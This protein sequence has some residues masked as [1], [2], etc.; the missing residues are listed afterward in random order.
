MSEKFTPGPW[1]VVS[2]LPVLAIATGDGRYRIVQTANQNNY[3][4]YGPSE[5]WLG[6]EHEANAALIAAAPDLYEALK[7]CLQFIEDNVR[8]AQ[9]NPESGEEPADRF[10]YEAQPICSAAQVALKK[11]RRE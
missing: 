6:I 8:F 11:A 7:D 10:S 3:K 4:H 5:R 1:R 9:P 2:D